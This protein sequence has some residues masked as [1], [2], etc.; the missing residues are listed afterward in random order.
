[1]KIG[2]LAQAAQCTP[3]TV[4]YYEKAGLLPP[5]SRSD[6]NYRV[7]GPAHLERL[8]FVPPPD[9]AARGEILRASG[10][11]VPLAGDIA[12]DDLAADLDGYSAADCSALLREAALSAMRRDIDAATVTAD[13]IAAARQRVRPSLDAAQVESLRAYA[14]RRLD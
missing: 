9:A 14:E 3:E 1:M 6:G 8:V 5:P 13:D 7:Y 4:R 12:L 2:E 10:K 11:N